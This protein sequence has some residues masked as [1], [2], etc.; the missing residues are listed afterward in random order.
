MKPNILDKILDCSLLT[1]MVAFMAS[2]VFLIFSALQAA[3][4]FFRG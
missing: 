2:H 4:S 1:L 3:M